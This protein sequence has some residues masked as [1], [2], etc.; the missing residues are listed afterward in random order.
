[1][2]LDPSIVDLATGRVTRIPVDFRGD[3]FFMSWTPDGQVMAAMCGLRSS[4]WKF[5]PEQH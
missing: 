4:I 2:S 3:T 5:T 1:V